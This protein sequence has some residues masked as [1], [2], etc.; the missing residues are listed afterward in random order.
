[1]LFNL[2]EVVHVIGAAVLFGTG[3][4]TALYMVMAN[5]TKNVAIIAK[6]AANVVNADWIF[7]G[8]AA[9]I[10]PITGLAMVYL[11]GYSLMAFWVWGSIVGY[12]IAGLFWLPVVYMQIRLR[13]MAVQALEG[14]LPL[15]RQ[16]YRIF[17]YWMLCGFPAFSSLV[18]VF[19]LMANGPTSAILN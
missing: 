18:V 5:R 3:I 15:P 19:F 13:D 6:A 11:K 7:T 16:Y 1:M 10:Q 4:G 9:I 17:R 12:I 2:I 8:T 14:N